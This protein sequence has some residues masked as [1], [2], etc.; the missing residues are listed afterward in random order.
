MTL[1]G[2]A[3]ALIVRQ[4][5]HGPLTISDGK[6]DLTVPSFSVAGKEVSQG[7]SLI[8]SFAIASFL[9]QENRGVKVLPF[10]S[11]D[12]DIDLP[13]DGI[14]FLNFFLNSAADL[15]V[16]GNGR[17]RSATSPMRRAPSPPAPTS[18]SRRSSSA[19]TCRPIP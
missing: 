15:T 3:S 6:L 13:I 8:G 18:R 14:D 2:E 1:V 7:G 11:L 19:S 10:L 9:P 16:G 12:A 17:L 4:N 5:K